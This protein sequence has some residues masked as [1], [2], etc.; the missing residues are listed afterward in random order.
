MVLLGTERASPLLFFKKEREREREKK[1]KKSYE[2]Q[3]N[4]DML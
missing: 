4:K 3:R 1:E 2:Y